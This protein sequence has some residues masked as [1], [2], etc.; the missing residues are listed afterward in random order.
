MSII[1]PFI[2]TKIAEKTFIRIFSKDTPEEE[3]KWHW[4]EEDRIIEAVEE[5]D[6]QFQ[7]DNCLPTAINTQI[8]IP[9]GIIHRII[10]G[11]GE[12]KIKVLK[13]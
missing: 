8:R 12:L 7:F 6:W 11:T 10:K 3:L 4:D 1:L 2:E 5:T 13:L 9:K